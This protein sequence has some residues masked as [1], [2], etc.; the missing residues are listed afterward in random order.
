[1]TACNTSSTATVTLRMITIRRSPCKMPL[2]M[3]S[4]KSSGG[5]TLRA[6]INITVATNTAIRDRYGL[7]KRKIRQTTPW[8]SSCWAISGSCDMRR[9]VM[10]IDM[11][12]PP[13][14]ETLGLTRLFRARGLQAAQRPGCNCARALV[15]TCDQRFL[16]GAFLAVVFL[17]G[18]F[19]AA[20]FF[21]GALAALAVVF[22]AGAFLAADFFAADLVVVFLAGA[23]LAADF[24]AGALAAFAGVFFAAAFLAEPAALLF[25]ALLDAVFLAPRVAP[26]RPRSS[27]PASFRTP[28]TNPKER[29]ASSAIFRML[30]PAAYR[31]AYWEASVVR[32]APVMREPLANAL[33]TAPP[34]VLTSSR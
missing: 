31:L 13:G 25:A 8:L 18:V 17:A 20:D 12:F 3:I 19:L 27:T 32:C 6:D 21:A 24:F 23:F 9:I 16:A 14:L 29:P 4:L 26:P 34:F 22:L 7:A 15:M 10:Y 30:S 33:A 1:M 5:V 11:C 28:C 2:S